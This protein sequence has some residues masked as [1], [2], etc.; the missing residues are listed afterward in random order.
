MAITYHKAIAD[1]G[2]AI[3]EEIASGIFSALL[4]QISL[5]DLA[6]GAKITRKL[7]I[8]NDGVTDVNFSKL[9]T[10]NTFAVFPAILFESSGD[11]QV[12]DDLTGNEVDASPLSVLI[13][14]GSHKFILGKCRCAY[15]VNYYR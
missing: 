1:N 15:R 5:A 10:D 14:A 13:P 6:N 3:G 4:P 9:A 7:Y 11:T 8:K 2:G 12:V